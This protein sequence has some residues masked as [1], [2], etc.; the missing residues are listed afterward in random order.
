MS[1][2]DTPAPAPFPR[3][4]PLI[5]AREGPFAVRM[6]K[7]L[8]SIGTH[9]PVRAATLHAA[10]S[11]V[12]S[13][14]I[15]VVVAEIHSGFSDG[16]KLPSMLKTLSAA[17]HDRRI[18][19][20]LWAGDESA[21]ARPLS[22]KVRD[23]L[24]GH[25]RG[26]HDKFCGVSLAS[27]ESHARLARE[28]GIQ[29]GIATDSRTE[30]LRASLGQLLAAPACGLSLEH[31]DVPL[32][33]EE[34]VIAALTSGNGLRVVIQ[35]QFDLRDGT[36]VGGEVLIRWRHAKLGDVPPAVL[37]PIVNRLG[38]DLLLFSYIKR[39]AIE[40]LHALDKAGLNLTL[41]VNASPNTICA[42]GLP[43]LLAMKMARAGLPANRLIIELTE[44]A[45]AYD[46]LC[47]SASITALRANGFQ[48][49]LDDFGAGTATLALLSQMPFDELKIDGSLVRSALPAS[50][51]REIIA[52]IVDLAR[53]FDLRL[54]A[55][56]IEDPSTIDQLYALGCHVGQGYA[57]ARPMET[58]D[59]LQLAA[60]KRHSAASDTSN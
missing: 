36:M 6:G 41:A 7:A 59:F 50:R 12:R 11:L 42:P 43:E 39:R 37:L 9:R 25:Q 31:A 28:W 26:A 38:L 13:Q 19:H 29:V 52:G 58:A 14:E 47:L 35:P 21:G 24:P 3:A 54:V 53:S 60:V 30:A 8:D 16:L 10:A 44:E 45:P 23:A 2:S 51:S 1:T 57:L 55:E 4:R 27:L 34:D 22:H 49:S 48:V 17:G 20:V 33:A 56:G 40:T 5:L 18:P 15:D 32:P 46:A